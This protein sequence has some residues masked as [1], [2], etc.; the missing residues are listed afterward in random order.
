MSATLHFLTPAAALAAPAAVV[1]AA[2]ALLQSRRRKRTLQTLGL[3][4]PSFGRRL[5]VAA[6]AAAASSLLIV[7]AAQPVLRRSQPRNVR[8]DSELFVVLDT[9]RSMA[10]R[11]SPS[12]RTREQRAKAFAVAFRS[13]LPQI[14]SGVASFTDR[15]L[16][17][18]L[19]STDLTTFDATV[20]QA[21]GID[22]PPPSEQL[23]VATTYDLLWQ[24]PSAGVFS[25]HA[26]HRLLVLLTDG[27]SQTYA[28]AHVIEALRAAH[29]GLLLVRFWRE[30][31]RVFV[32][33]KPA[34]Y[35]PSPSSSGPLAALGALSVGERVFGERDVAAAA[36]AARGFF[37]HGP[38]RRID[39]RSRSMPLAPWVT[40]LALLPLGLVLGR[41]GG[42]STLARG[43]VLRAAPRQ[44][45]VSKPA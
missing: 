14:A 40:L 36:A 19:P 31:E 26:R 35:L 38:T 45:P 34:G 2:A 30:D 1:P 41:R 15:L 18:L 29:A 7:A 23:A 11:A 13:T 37:G 21:V 12:S 8:T 3:A 33:G 28:P 4:P 16:P 39:G 24:L 43:A 10:A 17:H 42:G 9:S 32:H 6:A 20:D 22:R 25:P 44:K 5:G 27:E